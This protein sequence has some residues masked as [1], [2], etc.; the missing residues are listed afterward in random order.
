MV[1]INYCSSD[2]FLGNTSGRSEV[3]VYFRGKEILFSVLQDLISY[4]RMQPH[5]T[6]HFVGSSAGG[7]GIL[8]NMQ[9]ILQFLHDW[10][11]GNMQTRVILDD[12]W[13]TEEF[14]NDFPCFEESP[15]MPCIT[16]DTLTQAFQVWNVN[17]QSACGE[18][19]EKNASWNCIFGTNALRGLNNVPLFVIQNQYDNYQL[20]MSKLLPFPSTET[21]DGIL[22]RMDA[23]LEIGKKVRTEISSLDPDTSGFFSM[24]CLNH[25]TLKGDY[26]NFPV[27]VQSQTLTATLN[28]WLQNEH[29]VRSVDQVLNGNMN[30]PGLD[31]GRGGKSSQ[32]GSCSFRVGDECKYPQCNPNCMSLSG[33][34]AMIEDERI[35]VWTP[36]AFLN[37]SPKVA[38]ELGIFSTDRPNM[39]RLSL[40]ARKQHSTDWNFASF[41]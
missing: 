37:F 29:A 36:E 12:A 9:E 26:V 21:S 23:I 15:P 16:N 20:I 1:D 27:Q 34:V 18:S 6:I 11:F 35:T 24:G 8:V 13:F 38:T 5:H 25:H 39:E 3:G 40:L 22:K 7:I 31:A 19:Y 28:C 33:S 14:A 17:V 30:N 41:W 10:G 2:L 4:H 32:G